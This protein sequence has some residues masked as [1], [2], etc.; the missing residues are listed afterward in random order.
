MNN[1]EAPKL[2]QRNDLKEKHID[3]RNTRQQPPQNLESTDNTNRQ[4]LEPFLE[5]FQKATRKQ[6]KATITTKTRGLSAYIAP[7]TSGSFM[8]GRQLR[9]SFP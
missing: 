3:K 8:Q 6:T 2:L 7:L 4:R 1:R 9:L 5:L